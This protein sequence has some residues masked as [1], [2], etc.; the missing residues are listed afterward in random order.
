M[1]ESRIRAI[2]T[3]MRP[4]LSNVE[5]LADL[6][7]R[8]GLE[9]RLG[10][11]GDT[12]PRWTSEQIA[13]ARAYLEELRLAAR[14]ETKIAET[15]TTA[16]LMAEIDR[17][18]LWDCDLS[19][20]PPAKLAAATAATPEG[21]SAYMRLFMPKQFRPGV[22]P[23]RKQKE[24][25]P[26]EVLGEVQEIEKVGLRIKAIARKLEMHPDTV[27]KYA[28]RAATGKKEP[29]KRKTASRRQQQL[30]GGIV[31]YAE[32][33][34]Q[35]REEKGRLNDK[36]TDEM[37]A[38]IRELFSTGMSQSEVAR[39]LGVSRL[40]VIKYTREGPR[41][42]RP[43]FGGVAKPTYCRRCGVLCESAGA[44]WAHCPAAVKK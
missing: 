34:R 44:A 42:L 2:P 5:S 16:E 32:F 37:I 23:E 22:T 4:E 30:A 9:V 18:G 29:G 24:P 19:D 33:M 14:E 11:V 43:V 21:R 1:I 20:S 39:Q 36:L 38:K 13:R 25:L 6:A 3:F 17:R 40:S 26:P 31:S 10:E 41:G 12:D 35:T 8:V 7:I 27:M 28:R 15:L